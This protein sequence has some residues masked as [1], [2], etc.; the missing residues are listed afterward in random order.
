MAK[1]IEQIVAEKYR[2]DDAAKI[3][4]GYNEAVILQQQAFL[5]CY[6]DHCLPLRELLKRYRQ[7]EADLISTNKMW[8]PFQED[9]VLTGEVYNTMLELQERRNQLLSHVPVEGD[10][11]WISVN[12][13]Q[14][15][16]EWV[17]GGCY[18]MV[19]KYHWRVSGDEVGSKQYTTEELYKKF[20]S[21]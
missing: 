6:R 12:E 21:I 19:D 5:Q 13:A 11:G 1:D 3:K 9:D 4:Y 18:Y 7:W 2:K 8:W 20:K 14:R 17:D 16:A 15:F 10:D